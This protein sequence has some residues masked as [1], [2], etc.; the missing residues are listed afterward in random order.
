MRRSWVKASA[1]FATPNEAAKRVPG[2]DSGHVGRRRFLS[3]DQHDV[4]EAVGMELGDGSEVLGQHFT[5]ASLQRLNEVVRSFF[6]AV[7]DFF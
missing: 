5:V 4:A 2:A 3:D 7:L 1:F 6:G